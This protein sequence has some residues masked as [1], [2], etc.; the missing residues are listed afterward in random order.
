V[1]VDYCYVLRWWRLLTGLSCL[2]LV[3]TTRHLDRFS[4]CVCPK[5]NCSIHFEKSFWWNPNFRVPRCYD[6]IWWHSPNFENHYRRYLS[7]HVL[8]IIVQGITTSAYIYSHL[9]IESAHPHTFSH[10]SLFNSSRIRHI[11]SHKN[12][13]I[14]PTHPYHFSLI[15]TPHPNF[16]CSSHHIPTTFTHLNTSIFTIHLLFIPPSPI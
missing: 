9:R 14:L 3:A 7:F 2:A 4:F 8:N 16:Y 12:T 11:F 6:N 15:Q 10:S 5:K 1:K 13:T